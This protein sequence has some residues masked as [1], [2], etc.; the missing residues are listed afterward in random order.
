MPIPTDHLIFRSSSQPLLTGA[1]DRSCYL[2]NSPLL[3][4]IRPFDNLHAATNGVP[5]EPVPEYTS[6]N[7]QF[8]LLQPLVYHG[9][10]VEHCGVWPVSRNNMLGNEAA[11]CTTNCSGILNILNSPKAST[12]RV[13]EV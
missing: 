9:R 12:H 2:D 3:A 10:R 5:F 7:L 13:A 6:R 1:R 8:G 11:D 4:L